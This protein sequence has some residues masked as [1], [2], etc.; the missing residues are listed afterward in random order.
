MVQS[1]KAHQPKENSVTEESPKYIYQSRRRKLLGSIVHLV[2]IAASASVVSLNFAQVYWADIGIPNQN[3]YLDA[4]QFAAQLLD[5][6]I[7]TS[8]WHM[9]LHFTQKQMISSEGMTFGS[10]LGVY[11][12]QNFRYLFG[13]MF[14]SGFS[15]RMRFNWS[16]SGIAKGF[17]KFLT[18]YAALASFVGG[19]VSAIA[20]IP[21]L[22]WWQLPHFSPKSDLKDWL[23]DFDFIVSNLTELYPQSISASNLPN[24]SCV[25]PFGRQDSSCP[26]AGVSIIDQWASSVYQMI[27][28]GGMDWEASLIPF[29][30]TM[31]DFFWS[32]SVDVAYPNPL[33]PYSVSS[34]VS[35]VLASSIWSF[36]LWQKTQNVNVSTFRVDMKPT[37]GYTFLKPLVQVQCTQSNDSSIDSFPQNLLSDPPP[38]EP[39]S[40]DVPVQ[41]SPG[42]TST[43]YSSP[44]ISWVDLYDEGYNASLGASISWSS[45]NGTPSGDQN[46]VPLTFL[47]SIEANWVPVEVWIEPDQSNFVYQDTNDPLELFGSSANAVPIKIGVDWAQALNFTTSAGTTLLDVLEPIL[48]GSETVTNSTA[49]GLSF[50]LGAVITDALARLGSQYPLGIFDKEEIIADPSYVSYFSGIITNE[51]TIN[52]ASMTVLMEYSRLGYGYGLTTP[53]VRAAL[54]ALLTYTA[55]ATLFVVYYIIWAR[56]SNCW[57]QVGDVIALAMNSEQTPLLENTCAGIDHMATWKLSVAI[58]ETKPGHL[59]LVFANSNASLIHSDGTMRKVDDKTRYGRMSCLAT[60]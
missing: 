10:F 33:V 32:R 25:P 24:S 53:T 48:L 59:E 17:L 57:A 12:F 11:Q 8:L 60:H 46:L 44:N 54:V 22:H 36:W 2:P 58:R 19:P 4:L 3:T 6:L 18:I 7:V 39:E 21:K 28:S 55:L 50:L 40:T 49:M 13:P 30:I 43:N 14:L 20:I 35:L 52:P 29:N 42:F 47:C 34:S 45:G 38:Y 41:L 23:H 26:T 31:P 5:I 9:L 56:I 27:P 51:S 1:D 15:P 16:K 37:A